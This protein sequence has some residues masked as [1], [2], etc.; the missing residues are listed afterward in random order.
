MEKNYELLQGFVI[1]CYSY[2]EGDKEE[3]YWVDSQNC[4]YYILEDDNVNA[5]TWVILPY[6]P[7]GV[8]ITNDN[9]DLIVWLTEGYKE[10]D[11][12]NHKPKEI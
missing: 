2:S 9:Q 7:K 5:K 4:F 8:K 1:P 12:D 11:F 6:K 10:W 3:T